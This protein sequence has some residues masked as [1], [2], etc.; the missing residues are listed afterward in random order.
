LNEKNL[1]FYN[2]DEKFIELNKKISL[3]ASLE[4]QLQSLKMSLKS[5]ED[6]RSKLNFKKSFAVKNIVLTIAKLEEN[7]KMLQKEVEDDSIGKDDDDKVEQ[8]AS[9]KWVSKYMWKVFYSLFA[10]KD[11]A[12]KKSMY[13]FTGC[14]PKLKNSRQIIGKATMSKRWDPYLRKKLFQ[15]A[16]MARMHSTYFKEIYNKHRENWKHYFVCLMIVAKKI[17]YIIYSMMKNGTY[18]NDTFTQ[19]IISEK[20]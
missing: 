9:I 11:F 3:I 18:Y 17:V 16:N 14:D 20:T 5:F 10:C 15:A 2:K 4:K 1:F 8:I 6:V 7:I 12:S 13:A 19:S